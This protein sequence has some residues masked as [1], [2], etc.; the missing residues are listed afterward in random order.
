VS[1]RSVYGLA[2]L[3]FAFMLGLTGWGIAVV[4]PDAVVPTHWGISGEADGY[5]SA[6]LAFLMTPAIAAGLLVLLVVIPRVE[7]RRENLARSANAYRTAMSALLVF[8]ALVHAGVV[9]AGTGNPIPMGLLVGGGIGALF[10]VLGNVM[11]TVRSNYLFGVR[12]PWTLAS[13]LAWDRTHRLVGRL[14]FIAGLAMLLLALTGEMRLVIGVMIGFIV[15]V[16][17]VAFGY[18]YRV[19]KADPDRRPTSGR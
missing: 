17:V 10:M 11:A 15:L 18:S 14:F 4:G 3:V 5:A 12:T 2:V 9:L 16:L 1:L 8:M 19:W 13:D 7:P 6:L